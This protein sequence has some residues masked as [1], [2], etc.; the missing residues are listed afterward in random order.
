MTRTVHKKIEIDF[1]SMK[2]Y[3]KK[4]MKC[5]DFLIF[6]NSIYITIYKHDQ[7]IVVNL[8]FAI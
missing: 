8:I 7:E 6:T 5:Q 4:G 1:L 3:I 2:L